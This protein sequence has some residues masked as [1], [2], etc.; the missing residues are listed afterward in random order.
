MSDKYLLIKVNENQKGCEGCKINR[1]GGCMKWRT[2]KENTCVIYN[3]VEVEE[4]KVIPG[5]SVVGE[6][7]KTYYE[8]HKLFATKEGK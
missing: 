1:D 2:E 5:P 4:V 7:G 3:G 8:E 6:N